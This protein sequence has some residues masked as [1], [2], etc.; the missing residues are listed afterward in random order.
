MLKAQ[1]EVVETRSRCS[2]SSTRSTRSSASVAALKARAKAEA[3]QAQVVYAEEEAEVM[4]QQA[5]MQAQLPILKIK[6]E[7]AAAAAEAEILEAAAQ[8]EEQQPYS[9]EHPCDNPMDSKEKVQN[10]I[11]SQVFLQSNQVPSQPQMSIT[12]PFYHHDNTGADPSASP[13]ITPVIKQ[14]NLQHRQWPSMYI[15]TPHPN[16]AHPVL[17]HQHQSFSATSLNPQQTSTVNDMAKYL[18]KHELM[19]ATLQ[20]FD[21]D[22]QNY[23]SWKSSFLNVIKDLSLSPK[24]EL[25]LL[26]KWLGPKSNQQAKR[27]SAAQIN[28]ATEALNMIWQRL[29]DTYGAPEVIEHT[30]F[31]KVENFPKITARDAS[32]LTELGDLL[33]ELQLAKAEGYSP[34]LVFLD[35]AHGVNPIVE[36][37]PYFLQ[38]RWIS[39]ASKYKVDYDATFPPF[40]TFSTFVREQARIRNDPS[41]SFLSAAQPKFD[42]PVKTVLAL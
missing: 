38:E 30:L 24:E 7:A 9:K 16:V 8:F 32:K 20:T 2:A 27:I 34:G 22:P 36:K 39:H 40:S 25:D 33:L 3:V 19:S 15:S 29:E 13:Y 6:K 21:D 1:D 10:F 41:F 42:R 28:D 31:Q 37:L 17:N 5:E 12:N 11:D 14:E 4:K 35:T 26:V 23:R 18:M